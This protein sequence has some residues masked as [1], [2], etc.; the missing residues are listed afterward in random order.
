[1]SSTPLSEGHLGLHAMFAA[2]KLA[3]IA[4]LLALAAGLPLFVAGVPCISNTAPSNPLG[5]RLGTLTDLSLLRL[6][7]ALDPSPE[8]T[9]TL[10]QLQIRDL[11]STIAPAIG[12]AQTRLIVLLVIMAVLGCGLGLFVIARTYGAFDRYARQ[13]T[14]SCGGID[15][16][17]IPD[18]PAWRGLS[19][20][21][22]KKWF[23][24]VDVPGV[25]DI[26]V[27]GLFAIP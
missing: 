21:K 7:D 22:V 2:L 18:I 15:M 9:A 14:E 27:V 10:F 13:L 26:D 1:M 16:V 19:E 24:E 25:K 20:T 17:I 6:L 11:P 4:S 12:S 8:S 3:G 5:G 23:K